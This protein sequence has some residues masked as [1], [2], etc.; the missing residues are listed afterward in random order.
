MVF[1]EEPAHSVLDTRS[2]INVL[3]CSEVRE[4][5]L[6]VMVHTVLELVHETWL[7]E[8]RCLEVDLVLQGSV[9]SEREFFIPFFLTDPYLL[10]ERIESVYGEGHVRECERV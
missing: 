7:T 8:F 1:T 5:D 2:D 4:T 9:V 6:E 10:L 3:E